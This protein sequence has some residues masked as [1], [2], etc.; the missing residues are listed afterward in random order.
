MYSI[1]WI[2]LSNYMSP[3]KGISTHPKSAYQ[4][5]GP[6]LP[7]L[8]LFLNPY[9]YPVNQIKGPQCDCYVAAP[10]DLFFV[11]CQKC[12]DPEFQASQMTTALG[13]SVPMQLQQQC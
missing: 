4:S 5:Q 12:W 7:D 8:M 13:D 9:T 10:M 1:M 2:S 3:R 6:K 11:C